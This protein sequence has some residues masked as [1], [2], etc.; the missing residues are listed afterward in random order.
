MGIVEREREGDGL[1]IR[2]Q[3]GISIRDESLP[4][5][6]SHKHRKLRMNLT[7]T[8]ERQAS[9]GNDDECIICVQTSVA[10]LGVHGESLISV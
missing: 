3:D 7:M 10:T 5:S 2:A 1:S 6:F 8:F 9:D 4:Q